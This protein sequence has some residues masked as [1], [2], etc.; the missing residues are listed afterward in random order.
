MGNLAYDLQVQA[1][2]TA[3]IAGRI[4]SLAVAADVIKTGSGL[5]DEALTETIVLDILAV[6]GELA[7]GIERNVE[8]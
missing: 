8:D 1:A 3:R 2:H 6:I 7:G 4:R 5:C